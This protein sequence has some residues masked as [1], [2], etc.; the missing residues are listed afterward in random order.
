MNVEVVFVLQIVRTKL[1]EAVSQSRWLAKSI[2]SRIGPWGDVLS[3]IPSDDVRDSDL[4][5]SSEEGE[6]GKDDGSNDELPLVENLEGRGL[7]RQFLM[8]S[9]ILI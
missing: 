1:S 6:G 5:K 9:T 4:V 3:F 2:N 7:L 8:V